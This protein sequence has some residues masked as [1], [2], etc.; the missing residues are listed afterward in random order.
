MK[1]IFALVLLLCLIQGAVF[2]NER[3]K[4]YARKNGAYVNG[5]HR[6][7][8]NS[9]QLDNYSTQGNVN[10]YTGNSGHRRAQH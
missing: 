10:P 8:P 4:G 1:K 7:S 2:A 9:T 6:S 3:V 5:Y